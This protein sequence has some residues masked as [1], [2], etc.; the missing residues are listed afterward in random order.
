MGA[1][2]RGPD[3]LPARIG[4]E[5]EGNERRVEKPAEPDA[6]TLAVLAD[7]IHAIVPITRTD[8]GQPMG[9]ER[10]ALIECP[11]AM[12]KQGGG[13]VRDRRLEKAVMFAKLQLLSFEER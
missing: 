5:P 2:R 3:G 12:F 11:G 10:K 13:L 7:P 6:L 4:K 8:Q 9:A 1:P